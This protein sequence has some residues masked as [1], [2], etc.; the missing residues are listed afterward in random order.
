VVLAWVLPKLT[1]ISRENKQGTE[2]TGADPKG[3]LQPPLLLVH[4]WKYGEGEGEEE[5]EERRKNGEMVE[6]EEIS[7][8]FDSVLH[9]PLG[10]EIR[11]WFNL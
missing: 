11:V 2:R 1:I 4:Q 3:G 6:E 7:P 9:P 5:V 10:T 8:P